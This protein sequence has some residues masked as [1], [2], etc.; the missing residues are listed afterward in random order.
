VYP[1]TRPEQITEQSKSK[2]KVKEKGPVWFL[3]RSSAER[4]L[5]CCVPLVVKK[6]QVKT[7]WCR[8]KQKPETD[9]SPQDKSGNDTS[10]LYFKPCPVVNA[11]EM[12]PVPVPAHDV[13]VCVCVCVCL[14]L[15]K[16]NTSLAAELAAVGVGSESRGMLA[17][18][19]G[20]GRRE[21]VTGRAKYT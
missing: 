8:K 10:R 15:R 6:E 14:R 16:N 18:R 13:C 3:S 19:G 2:K 21:D 20:G 12:M 9:L 4:D 17:S 11:F 1:K 5:H 7:K